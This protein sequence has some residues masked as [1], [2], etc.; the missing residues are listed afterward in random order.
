MVS[1]LK[2]LRNLKSFPFTF[3]EEHYILA[4]HVE[5]RYKKKSI[6]FLREERKKPLE[7]IFSGCLQYIALRSVLGAL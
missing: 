1:G 5:H 7:A 2:R 3:F 6:F 4:L